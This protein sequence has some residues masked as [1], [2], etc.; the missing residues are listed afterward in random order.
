MAGLTIRCNYCKRIAYW[1]SPS[2]G[3]QICS[4]CK[5]LTD[6]EQWAELALRWLTYYPKDWVADVAA[7]IAATADRMVA[8]EPAVPVTVC[9]GCNGS[10]CGSD[11]HQH[12]KVL[13]TVGVVA[14]ITR[15]KEVDPDA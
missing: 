11:P 13:P 10:K 9:E 4:S 14:R 6:R 1:L 15:A 8:L 5:D 2:T 12:R 7:F 3:V